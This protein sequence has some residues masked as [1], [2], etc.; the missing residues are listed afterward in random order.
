MIGT[1]HF[2]SARCTPIT[3]ETQ[4]M[5]NRDRSIGFRD[6]SASFRP[7]TARRTAY[8]EFLIALSRNQRLLGKE[9]TRPKR[10]SVGDAPITDV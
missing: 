8:A 1:C 9:A 5:L 3:D 4:L 2:Q 10:G 6:I 7:Q